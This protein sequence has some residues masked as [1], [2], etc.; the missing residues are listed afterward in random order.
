MSEKD[1]HRYDDIID[2]PRFIS[3]GRRHMS[4]YDRAAQFA[5]F[6]ALTGYDEAIE[7][8]GRTT[9]NEIVLGESEMQMLD[10]CFAILRE[11]INEMPVIRIRY[12]EPD[13]YKDGGTYLEEEVTV[14]KIDM[15]GRL[16]FTNDKRHFDLDSIVSISGSIFDSYEF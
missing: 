14:K 6:D 1:P 11:H 9:E 2:L 4:N 8:T 10:H 16:L 5:P 15:T 7:E 12:F 3:K 13:M